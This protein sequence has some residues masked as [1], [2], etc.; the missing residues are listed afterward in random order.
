MNTFNEDLFLTSPLAKHLYESYAKDQPIIDYHCHL[1]AQEI[2]EN[3][4]FEDLGQMWLAH[5]HYKW[6]AMR[7]FGID[8]HY[9]TG[10][11]SFREKFLKF[12]EILPYLAGNPLYVWCALELKRYFDID[13]AVTGDNAERIYDQ[14]K[15]LIREKGMTPQWCMEKSNVEIVCTT[16]D[17]TDQLTY[18]K[19]LA[20]KTKVKVLTAFRPDNAMFMERDSFA[21]YVDI[22]ETVS[23]VEIT[24]FNSLIDALETRLVE[25][26]K[27]GT[28]VSD[29]G[30]PEFTYA[31]ASESEIEE[32]FQRAMNN[33]TVCKEDID[34]YRTAFLYR[35]GQIYFRHAFVMQLHVGTYLG[36]NTSKAESIGAST[37]FDCIDDSTAVMSVGKLLDRLTREGTLPKTILYP[38]DIT[39]MESF[40]VLAAGF[41]DSSARGKVQLGAPWWFN[42]QVAGLERQFE[43]VS[44][45]YPLSLSVGMLTD[46]RSFISY[47][48]HELYRRVLCD[49]LAKLVNR[50]EYFSDEKFLGETIRNICYG[51]VKEYFG[52]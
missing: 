35:M 42:D 12:A 50:G 27:S 28:P 32:I 47:P 26:R 44:N 19:K 5:D 13:E 36:A 37:G 17:P 39:K 48:R 46:S 33:E 15:Q 16:E 29:D 2:Y 3:E 49:Y 24:S 31:E 52:F 6:R 8:E 34:R 51:N 38:L 20:G 23:G 10:G 18:H 43:S 1:V 22:L 45:L 25:F 11:A 9:I 21:G 7:T 14:T 4:V 40:A 30:I 41:C